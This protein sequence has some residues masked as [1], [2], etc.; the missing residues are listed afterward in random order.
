M[1]RFAATL[2]EA[3]RALLKAFAAR[4]HDVLF[5]EREVPWYAGA[6]RDLADPGYCCLAY[7]RTLGELDDWRSEIADADAVRRASA[8][9][10][11]VRFCALLRHG[12]IAMF[13]SMVPE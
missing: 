5:L 6:H 7:Y 10:R 11:G 8:L 13:T 2:P 12:H 3:F 1:Y 4:G 9:L